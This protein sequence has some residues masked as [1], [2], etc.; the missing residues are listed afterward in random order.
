MVDPLTEAAV[1]RTQ[2]V[3]GPDTPAEV[4]VKKPTQ[5]TYSLNIT[6]EPTQAGTSRSLA[7]RPRVGLRLGAAL[8]LRVVCEPLLAPAGESPLQPAA[9]AQAALPAL[10]VALPVPPPP[11]PANAPAPATAPAG[12]QAAAPAANPAPGMAMAP[13]EEQVQLAF[14]EQQAQHEVQELA[15]V[16]RDEDLDPAAIRL[17]AM[18]VICAVATGAAMQRRSAMVRTAVGRRRH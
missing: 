16:A 10:A 9:P 4:D 12:A 17:L 3:A 11:V 18:S 15:M 6:C 14:A 2:V 7:L 13:E 5:L 8:R 1:L